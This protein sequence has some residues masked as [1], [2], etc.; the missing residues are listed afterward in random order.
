[1]VNIL[2]NRFIGLDII[3]GDCRKVDYNRFDKKQPYL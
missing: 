1:M 2:K 3:E